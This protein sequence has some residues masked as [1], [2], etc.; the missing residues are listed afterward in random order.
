VDLPRHD[1]RCSQYQRRHPG[2]R[3]AETIG[4]LAHREI[5]ENTQV[6]GGGLHWR[7]LADRIAQQS[8]PLALQGV[9]SGRLGFGILEVLQARSSQ[10]LFACGSSPAAWSR[11]IR[12]SSRFSGASLR[13]ASMIRCRTRLHTHDRSDIP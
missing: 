5:L 7:E 9:V 1:R 11:A 10:D 8:T 12:V 3:D 13:L 4:R 6:H 2:L